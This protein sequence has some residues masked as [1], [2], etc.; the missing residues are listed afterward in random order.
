LIIS[1]FSIQSSLYISIE[2][3]E[4]LIL[5]SLLSTSYSL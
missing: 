3:K 2:S 5:Y 1:T 4:L